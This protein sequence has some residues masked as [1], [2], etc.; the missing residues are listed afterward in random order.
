MECE[1][2]KRF[3]YYQSQIQDLVNKMLIEGFWW[4]KFPTGIHSQ[5]P[6]IVDWGGKG[7][8]SIAVSNLVVSSLITTWTHMPYDGIIQCYLPPGRCDITALIPAGAGT[9]I[10]DPGRMQGWVDLGWLYTEM[11]IYRQKTVTHPSTN[12]VRRGLTSFMR[13]T[14]PE[15]GEFL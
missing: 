4:R 15:V 1:K 8:R 6:D 7:K 5:I 2:G 13:R 9:R 12:R 11:V 3:Q 10:S 14:L